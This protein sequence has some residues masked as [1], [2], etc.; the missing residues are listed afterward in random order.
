MLKLSQL[1]FT[2]PV[3]QPASPVRELAA[4]RP[5][6]MVKAGLMEEARTK[7][8]DPPSGAGGLCYRGGLQRRG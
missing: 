4:H 6:V 8:G 2:S 1:L 5:T 7:R 3:R